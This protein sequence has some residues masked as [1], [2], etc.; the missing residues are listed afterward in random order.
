MQYHE[1][2][3]KILLVDDHNLFRQGLEML[4]S[5]LESVSEIL[6]AE[7]GNQAIEILKA[8]EDPDLILLDYNLGDGVGVDVLLRIKSRDPSI[9]VAMIS[10]DSNPR[11]VQQCL[12]NGA[13]GYIEKN[14]DTTELLTAVKTLLDGNYYIPPNLMLKTYSSKNEEIDETSLS[15]FT[16]VARNVVREKDLSLRLD[17]QSD[18]P[19]EMVSAFNSLLEELDDKQNHLNSLAFTDELTGLA[20][21]RFFMERLDHA[22]KTTKRSKKDFSLI[23]LDLDKFKEIN[24]TLGHDI[25]DK[26]LIEVSNRLQQSVRELDTVARLGGDEFCILLIDI[27]SEDNARKVLEK[28][29]ENIRKPVQLANKTIT[30]SIS[31]G[32]TLCTGKSLPK[33]II[34]RADEALYKVKQSGKN[35]FAFYKP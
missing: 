5:Q 31:I 27:E 28:I 20:N 16:D 13:N 24:D 14:M 22:I 19:H 2:I 34:K 10:G 35:G 17:Q 29:M 33:D 30:P 15:K 32:V 1:K 3:M 6:H 12:S 4:L 11:I 25:G 18:L 8:G 23:Y 9:P 26:L 21:R 7:S